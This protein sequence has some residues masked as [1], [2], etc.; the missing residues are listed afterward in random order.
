MA[1]R[2]TPTYGFK[3]SGGAGAR[4]RWWIRRRTRQYHFGLPFVAQ[5]DH[6]ATMTALKKQKR[7]EKK[8]RR[9]GPHGTQTGPVNG[10]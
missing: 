8:L 3:T 5:I 10:T 7:I 1:K 4:H 6:S 9:K 2:L